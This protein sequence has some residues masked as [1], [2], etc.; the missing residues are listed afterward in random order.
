[1]EYGDRIQ[2]EIAGLLDEERRRRGVA[3]MLRLW[4]RGLADV[5]RAVV[6]EWRSASN[7]AGG[8]RRP[9]ADLSGDVRGALRAWRRAP[10]VSLT[11]VAMLVFGLAL[12]SAIFAF[13]DGYLFRPLP[14]P[15]PDR[16]FV[17]RAPDARGEFLLASEAEALRTSEVGHLGFVDANRSARVRSSTFEIG[18]RQV[19]LHV[20]GLG[21]NFGQI[22]RVP[23]EMGRY[24]E[25]DEHLAVEPVPIWLTHRSWQREFGADPDVFG[26]RLSGQGPD[27]PM[28][29]VVVGVT[30]AEVTT[31]SPNFGRSNA[32]PDAFAPAA[33]RVRDPNSRIVILATPFVRLPDD[34]TREE[35]EGRIGAALQAIA[36]AP[37]GGVRRVRL[38]SLHEEQIAS[39]RP[40]ARLFMLGAVLALALV[41]INLVHLLL[42]RGVA[43]ANEVATRAALG[44][45]RWRIAR[46]FLVESLVYGVPGIG[47]GLLAGWWL[48]G[49]IGAS[50]PTRGSDAVSYA[51]VSVTF[52]WRVA[53][54]ACVMGLVMAL[55]GGAFPAWRAARIPLAAATRTTT[56]GGLSLRWSQAMLASEVA[57]S[58]VVLA[59]AIFLGLGMWRYV[60]QP[61]GFQLQDRFHLSFIAS[62]GQ[63]D[64]LVDWPVVRDAVR[65]VPGVR[66][67]AVGRTRTIREPLEAGGRVFGEDE[68]AASG[69]DVE[70]FEARGV[71]L[72]AGR[73]PDVSE[74]A[75]GAPVVVV[76]ES[77][78]RRA[79][80]DSEAVGQTL[81]VGTRPL[82]VIGVVADQRWSLARDLPPMVF[83]PQAPTDERQTM[84]L[85]APGLSAEMLAERIG[86]VLQTV[87]PG[88][89][90]MISERTFESMFSDD[91]AAV[92]V[93]RPIILVLGV[94]AFSLA[95]I[96]LFGLV[97]YLVE[98]RTRDFGIRVALG[99]RP[100]VIAR[101]VLRQAMAPAIAGLIIGLP[102]AWMLESVARASMVG[103]EASGALAMAIVALAMLV[104]VMVASAGP[105]RR[106]L[107]IDPT[108]ALR[109][110]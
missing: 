50:L 22:V 80:P 84:N 5:A 59:G 51:V 87:A 65:A 18:G 7:G 66:A 96:G 69:V 79:W 88:S 82:E 74:F 41:T 81:R 77:M 20:D 86:S 44:A 68:A 19:R 52:D 6:R 56:G 72:R 29:V 46:L 94:F 75:A 30:A 71:G 105:A 36:P 15:D 99:A 55:C 21:E 45:S 27:G 100:G 12:A 63:P 91:L 26:R 13:S 14:F 3:P 83:V 1:M 70:Y 4:L 47:G 40:T 90:A 67:A 89:R 10:V 54:F 16:L 31:F 110:E 93:Q 64:E 102:A 109:V 98:R 58:T 62:A 38:D 57:V 60:N 53:A 32:V 106:A 17:V 92:R 9:M 103:W 78:A 34:M 42:A 2:R 23:M 33:A 97:S 24:F 39:A 11:I 95:G 104:V 43:R 108:V 37:S 85:W 107:S 25:P 76:D 73:L 35:A 101:Y 49:V 28:D 61:L 48:S 8:G